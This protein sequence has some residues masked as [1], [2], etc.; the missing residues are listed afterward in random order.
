LLRFKFTQFFTGEAFKPGVDY[1]DAAIASSA[2]AS[3]MA[4]NKTATSAPTETSSDGNL[5]ASD[6][7]KGI[8]DL[9]KKV[10][11]GVGIPLSILVLAILGFFGWR[12]W[13]KH[14]EKVAANFSASGAISTMKSRD[15]LVSASFHSPRDQQ[16][17]GYRPQFIPVSE[18]SPRPRC[19]GPMSLFLMWKR[20]EELVAKKCLREEARWD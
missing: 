7:P 1:R 11:L 20:M 17:R 2:I 4:T 10:G 12:E 5:V 15:E 16:E 14:H 3:A 9:A 18:M 6:C 8:V 13:G 19:L